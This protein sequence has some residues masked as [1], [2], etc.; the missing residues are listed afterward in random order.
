MAEKIRRRSEP[1]E[2]GFPD[3]RSTS[4]R[5]RRSAQRASLPARERR[6]HDGLRLPVSRGRRG[7]DRD[8]SSR[9]L[10]SQC[11]WS[12]E[13]GRYTSTGRDRGGRHLQSF[14]AR[15]PGRL[16]V[17]DRFHV[18][19]ARRAGT[20]HEGRK[21]DASDSP[22]HHEPDSADRLRQRRESDSRPRVAARSGD[23]GARRA[24]R[25]PGADH[26]AVA[27]REFDPLDRGR[28]RGP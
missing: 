23:G 2:S 24:G 14:H 22:R 6:L 25:R 16:Q 3:E 10:G 18:H 8:E 28:R 5:D 9:F 13:A 15:Q 11:L 20:T 27:H 4:P 12:L 7:S 1:R 17:R 19:R 21:A 26:P